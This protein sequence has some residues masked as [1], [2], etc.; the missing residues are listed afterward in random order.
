[1]SNWVFW[2]GMIGIVAASMLLGGETSPATD[3]KSPS[4]PVESGSAPPGE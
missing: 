2:P 4:E 1:M 3:A